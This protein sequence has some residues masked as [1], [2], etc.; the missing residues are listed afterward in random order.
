MR[1]SAT[2]AS[3]RYV[4][5]T[6]LIHHLSLPVIA[7]KSECH[8]LLQ[9]C[10]GGSGGGS[11]G[12]PVASFTRT[13]LSHSSLQRHARALLV[14]RLFPIACSWYG[15]VRYI[16][17]YHRL[18]FTTCHCLLSTIYLALPGACPRWKER[19]SSH[20]IRW[21]ERASS[22]SRYTCFTPTNFY[23]HGS[24]SA[25]IYLATASC[26]PPFCENNVIL[27]TLCT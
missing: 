5:K 1:P 16:G 26:R 6:R 12:G 3:V 27:K 18:F 17:S 13:T 10:G 24:H 23:V 20:T 2:L 7:G 25:P 14:M 4:L 21:K 15:S 8:N 22:R 9:D 11:Q 19:A